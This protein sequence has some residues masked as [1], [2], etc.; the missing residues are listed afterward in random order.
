[1]KYLARDDNDSKESLI[2]HFLYSFETAQ[3][4]FLCNVTIPNGRPNHEQ[5]VV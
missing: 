5:G 4:L 2:P 3:M 1:M